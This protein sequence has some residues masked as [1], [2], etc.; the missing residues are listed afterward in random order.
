MA[1]LGFAACAEPAPQ[2]VAPAPPRAAIV[3]GV[4]PHHA[5]SIVALGDT[6]RTLFIEKLVGREQ[7]EAQSLA[8]IDQVAQENPAFVVHLGDLVNDGESSTEWAYFDRLIAPLTTRQIGIKPVL[9]NHDAEPFAGLVPPEA[10]QRFPALGRTGWYAAT[11]RELG[12][13]WLNTNLRGQQRKQ[14]TTW[15]EHAMARFET[16]RLRGVLVFTHHP[17]YTNGEGRSGHPYVVSAIVPRFLRSPLS[18]AMLSGHVHGYERFDTA[19]KAFIVSG[20][21]GGPRVGYRVGKD[22]AFPAAYESSSSG[23]RPFNYVVITDRRDHLHC[24][25]KCLEPHA[26]CHA[27]LLEEFDLPLL[28]PAPPP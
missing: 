21:A 27:G 3:A 26:D 7:N 23:P 24:A 19:G 4:A 9:G 15:F 14:Q 20:G 18:V 25:V 17:P 1:L 6:Q 5:D 12:L 2:P 28:Q 22:A 10:Q 8:I 16:Q 11:Y 13:I